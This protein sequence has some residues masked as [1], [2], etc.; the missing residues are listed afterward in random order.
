[1]NI[2]DIPRFSIPE[3]ATFEDLVRL[4][5]QR[6]ERF[7]IVKSFDIESLAV[8]TPPTNL[9]TFQI[10]DVTRPSDTDPNKVVSVAQFLFSETNNYFLGARPT[11]PDPT[12][13][14]GFF[15]FSNVILPGYFGTVHHMSCSSRYSMIDS[16]KVSI[17]CL[18]DLVK[19]IL[20]LTIQNCKHISPYMVELLEVGMF[21][22][23]EFDRMQPPVDFL[24]NNF[25]Y[26]LIF[27]SAEVLVYVRN[28]SYLSKAAFAFYL[29]LLEIS[30]DVVGHEDTYLRGR[31]QMA[32]AVRKFAK[33]GCRLELRGE[34]GFFS[35][36]KLVGSCLQLLKFDEEYIKRLIIRKNRKHRGS[37]EEIKGLVS[38]QQHS[39]DGS[40]EADAKAEAEAEQLSKEELAK[41]E[42]EAEKECKHWVR[43]LLHDK[44]ELIEALSQVNMDQDDNDQGVAS[45]EGEPENLQGRLH[46]CLHLLAKGTHY[47]MDCHPRIL[48]AAKFLLRLTIL[49]AAKSLLRLNMWI[50][51]RHLLA[52]ETSYHM[53]WHISVLWAENFLLRLNM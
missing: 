46:L 48:C 30:L 50:P 37:M 53:V 4:K 24:S 14:H 26:L 28:W 17:T 49:C 45:D 27:I 52:K 34:D 42:K 43:L 7:D 36:K 1:M 38:V 29:G 6:L 33:L 15:V 10:I 31:K 13:K 8:V 16:V 39:N 5:E 12:A 19:Q 9:E 25:T 18:P 40:C 41:E 44:M 51:R 21:L 32:S 3:N 22:F 2:R 35:L 47:Q 20:L 11:P 23:G